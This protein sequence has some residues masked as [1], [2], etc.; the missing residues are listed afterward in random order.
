MK[1]WKVKRKKKKKIPLNIQK[2]RNSSGPCSA[3]LFN[4]NKI[5]IF[6]TNSWQ[7]IIIFLQIGTSMSIWIMLC[8][9]HQFH[10][11]SIL[12]TVWPL[13]HKMLLQNII[14]LQIKYMY[15]WKLLSHITFE[16]WKQYGSQVSY[17]S[18]ISLQVS[19]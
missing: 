9:S 18:V 12:L 15:A 10:L 1:P 14:T 8:I 5:N 6:L 13:T 19:Q 16:L 3:I 4:F 17:A 7:N 2:H 11:V